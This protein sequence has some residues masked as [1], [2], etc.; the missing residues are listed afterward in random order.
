MSAVWQLVLAFMLA[1]RL[2]DSSST[3]TEG[4]TGP[5]RNAIQEV[6]RD[7]DWKLLA[8][9]LNL[10]G[11]VSAIELTCLRQTSDSC[12]VREILDRFIHSQPLESC[13][14]TAE[15]LV[16]ALQELGGKLVYEINQLKVM[17]KMYDPNQTLSE[18]PG[19]HRIPRVNMAD[20]DSAEPVIAEATP[21]P[22]NSHWMWLLGLCGYIL[23]LS[24][25][26]IYKLCRYTHALHVENRTLS[27]LVS[28]LQKENEARQLNFQEFQSSIQDEVTQLSHRLGE[29]NTKGLEE[30]INTL[31]NSF[32]RASVAVDSR[33]QVLEIA[34]SSRQEELRNLAQS[35]D[36]H[37]KEL[38]D[39]INVLETDHKELQDRVK[40]LQADHEVLVERVSTHRV[41]HEGL[42]E[43]VGMLQVDHK[44]LVERANA[45]ELESF[46]RQNVEL[47]RCLAQSQAKCDQLSEKLQEQNITQLQDLKKERQEIGNLGSVTTMNTRTLLTPQHD[48]SPNG[49]YIS[50]STVAVS[51]TSLQERDGVAALSDSVNKEMVAGQDSQRM[52]RSLYQT[53]VDRTSTPSQPTQGTTRPASATLLHLNAPSFF[54]CPALPMSPEPVMHQLSNH[55]GPSHELLIPSPSQPNQAT[56]TMN[57]IAAT[58]YLD[59]LR[60]SPPTTKVLTWLST[61]VVNWQPLARCLDMEEHDIARIIRENQN[62]IREQCYRM[63]YMCLQQKENFTYQDL[64]KA[65]LE[66][67]AGGTFKMFCA[68]VKDL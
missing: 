42:R 20:S 16:R 55:H 21:F 56:I 68:Q 1:L 64:G 59:T 2:S 67:A 52:T 66:T 34:N 5:E 23:G 37:C 62:D 54:V 48:V 7:V 12:Y 50:E 58:A 10:V 49:L 38:Q 18:P 25:I 57:S 6:L 27:G 31:Q 29:V 22:L 15:K 24:L 63:L 47:R 3:E 45:L 39:S 41:D 53:S 8:N 44:G 61:Q 26:V 35:R 19:L 28:E 40:S 13:Q 11:Q 65:L 30:G 14:E 4:C 17:F 32:S 51:E 46:R 9:Q 36:S 60:P 43:S 33:L